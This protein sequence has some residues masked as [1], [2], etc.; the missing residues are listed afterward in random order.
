MDCVVGQD[1]LIEIPIAS[2]KRLLYTE[3]T[4]KG[5]REEVLLVAIASSRLFSYP[6]GEQPYLSSK[7]YRFT[8]A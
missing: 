5:R 2:P 4:P 3:T 7:R 8:A 1:G 6:E